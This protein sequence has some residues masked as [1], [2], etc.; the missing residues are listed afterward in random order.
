MPAAALLPPRLTTLIHVC[1]CVYVCVWERER[2]RERKRERVS[3]CVWCVLIHTWCR[4]LRCACTHHTNVGKRRGESRGRVC[5]YLSRRLLLIDKD[6]EKAFYIWHTMHITWARVCCWLREWCRSTE[7]LTHT[8]ARERERE[9]EREGERV[10]HRGDDVGEE[11]QISCP[12]MTH[13]AHNQSVH[14]HKRT[15]HSNQI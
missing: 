8:Q 5:D 3:V 2:E 9:R 15:T 7:T 4:R 6:K 10:F 12:H 1:V 13:N 11:I 14:I